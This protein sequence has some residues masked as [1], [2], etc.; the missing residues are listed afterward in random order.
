MLQFYPS[1]YLTIVFFCDLDHLVVLDEEG[2]QVA[3]NMPH[4]EDCRFVEDLNICQE[5]Q[6]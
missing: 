4:N 2:N 1:D 5:R 6:R 3:I